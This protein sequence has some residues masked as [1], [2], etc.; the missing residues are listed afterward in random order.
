M[1]KING[2]RYQPASE[3]VYVRL[4]LPFPTS[5]LHLSLKK[6]H[7][8]L[9]LVDLRTATASPSRPSFFHIPFAFHLVSGE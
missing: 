6:I 2:V 1:I 4:R 7:N 5:Y 3:K 9:L 8:P